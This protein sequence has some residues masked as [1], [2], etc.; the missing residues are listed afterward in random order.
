MDAQSQSNLFQLSSIML[1]AGLAELKMG[2][3]QPQVA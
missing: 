3:I 1:A 2:H